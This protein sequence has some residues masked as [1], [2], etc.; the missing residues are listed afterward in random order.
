MQITK[1]VQSNEKEKQQFKDQIKGLDEKVASQADEVLEAKRHQEKTDLELFE[2]KT[3]LKETQKKMEEQLK[4]TQDI[5]DKGMKDLENVNKVAET[6]LKAEIE[7]IKSQQA[8][9]K[10]ASVK[11]NLKFEE[12]ERNLNRR[13]QDLINEKKL[14]ETNMSDLSSM[15]DT[16]E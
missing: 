3:K 16:G 2:T 4:E 13:I 7:K 10:E 1:L 15:K 5:Y 6:K 11:A 12:Q 8:Q 9:D 14:L